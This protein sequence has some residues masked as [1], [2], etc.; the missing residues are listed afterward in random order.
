MSNN[1]SNVSPLTAT[2]G[3]QLLQKI[4]RLAELMEQP[5]G[6][7]GDPIEQMVTF[8]DRWVD[9]AARQSEAMQRMNAKLDAV[10]DI[11]SRSR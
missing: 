2:Q 4:D 9:Q 3:R 8:L 6:P 1:S 10:L 7:G 5:A 11:L